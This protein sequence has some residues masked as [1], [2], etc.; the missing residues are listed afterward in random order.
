MGLGMGLNT[1][2]EGISPVLYPHIIIKRKF[3][4]GYNHWVGNF[5]TP[6]MHT[7]PNQNKTQSLF[8]LT[9][10]ECLINL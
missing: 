2:D 4:D 8:L 6:P 3:K 9:T 7:T 5:S 10:E 1:K